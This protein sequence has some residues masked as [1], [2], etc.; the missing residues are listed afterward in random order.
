MIWINNKNEIS[1]TLVVAALETIS[2]RIG[3]LDLLSDNLQSKTG[4]FSYG[5]YVRKQF[6]SIIPQAVA[7]WCRALNH[8]V[9][10][11]TFWGQCDPLDLVPDDLD[12]VFISAYTQ[13]SALAYALSVAFKKRGALTVIGG[14]HAVAV[15]T[16]RSMAAAAA[17]PAPPSASA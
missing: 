16:I 14:P 13:C 4:R 7:V 15:A 10:Y 2:M 12:V 5:L 8:Q 17:I 11:A 6:I 3:I 9:H 1:E